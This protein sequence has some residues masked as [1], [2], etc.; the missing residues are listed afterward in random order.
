MKSIHIRA[1]VVLLLWCVA[2]TAGAQFEVLAKRVP[3]AANALVLVNA[4]D[5][6][7]SQVAKGQNWQADRIKRFTSG[8]TDVPPGATQLVMAAQLDLASAQPAWRAAVIQL[9]ATPSLPAVARQFGGTVDTVADLPAIR[10]ADDSY[11]VQLADRL[12]GSLAP[13]NRQALTRWLREPSGN[14]SPYLAEAVG[15]AVKGTEVIMAL[16]LTDAIAA[17][18]VQ[19]KLEASDDE[20]LLK[21]KVDKKELAQVLASIKGVMLGITFG[22]RA[23]GKI[24]VDFGRDVSIA[25]P[26]AKPL[27]LDVLAERG[28]HV[29]EFADWKVSAA[30]TRISLEGDV[31]ASALTRLSSLIEL[32]TPALTVASQDQQTS[33]PNPGSDQPT[34][35]ATKEYFQAIEH[36]FKDLADRKGEA[37]TIGQK[38]Q[39]YDNYSRKVDRLPML[40][41]D[42]MMLNFGAYVAD[43]FRCASMACKGFGIQKRVA[44][45]NVVNAG[46]TTG[47]GYDGYWYDGYGYWNRGM[48]RREQQSERTQVNTQLRGATATS[49]QQIRAAIEDAT[50]T[51]RREMTKKYQI[52]F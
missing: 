12:V 22:E 33:Q 11:I 25:A 49:L 23:F 5:L 34:A 9:D 51:V 8:L 20:T 35:E 27:L 18:D 37:K 30:G 38:G 7:G 48:T 42:E 10:L 39:W 6:F 13:A 40:N 14:L 21:S 31:T 17:D 50:A 26:I 3:S 41:V 46:V 28:L 44:Q 45:V 32:P 36:L 15:Y 47:Y 29:E 24:K 52:E 2:A 43:Q 16:D 4:Q 1:V 19:A